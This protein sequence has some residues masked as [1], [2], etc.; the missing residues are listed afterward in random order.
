ML[1][2]DLTRGSRPWLLTFA[3]LRLKTI[4]VLLKLRGKPLKQRRPTSRIRA[5]AQELLQVRMHLLAQ[6]RLALAPLERVV[7]CRQE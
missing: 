4:F 6:L 2:G 5:A 3:A 7:H 1:F